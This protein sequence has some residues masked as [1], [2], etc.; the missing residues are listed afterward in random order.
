M[1]LGSTMEGTRES[2]SRKLDGMDVKLGVIAWYLY[3]G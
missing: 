1:L 3:R 2:I